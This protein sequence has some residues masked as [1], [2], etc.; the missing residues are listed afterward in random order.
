MKTKIDVEKL[1]IVDVIGYK[2]RNA[3]IEGKLAPGEQLIEVDLAQTYDASRN[4][5]REVLHL[6]VRDG[7]ATSIRHRGVF[8]RKFHVDDLQDL[9]TAR[10][11]LELHAVRSS[12]PPSR[13]LLNKMAR[14]NKQAERALAKEQWQEVGSLSL[15]FH[16]LVV[17]MLGSKLLDEFFL[18]LCAQLRLVFF[19][20]PDEKI[21]QAPLWI[22]WERRIHQCLCDGNIA[23]AEQELADYLDASETALS[24]VVSTYQNSGLK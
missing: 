15:M 21:V 22:E 17:S 6:L 7:L 12:A 20:G 13:T 11:T 8:V 24:K 23:Q 3:I 4:S 9:Y 5:I 16:Q 1:S 2:L 18:T 10:R 14:N 19:A